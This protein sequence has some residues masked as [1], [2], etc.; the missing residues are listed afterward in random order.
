MFTIKQTFARST[1]SLGDT[2]AE[3]WCGQVTQSKVTSADFPTYALCCF[4]VVV[5]LVLLTFH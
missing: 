3:V 4:R 2:A 1:F 5:I